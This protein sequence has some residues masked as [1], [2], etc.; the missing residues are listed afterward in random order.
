MY[1]LIVNDDEEE[2]ERKELYNEEVQHGILHLVGGVFLHL[3]AL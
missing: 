1:L 2:K 3:D